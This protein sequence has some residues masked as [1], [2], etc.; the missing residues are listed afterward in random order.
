MLSS[1]WDSRLAV[2]V[3][4]VM[5]Q[6]LVWMRSDQLSFVAHTKGLCHLRY[7]LN[8]NIPWIQSIWSMP[9]S[10]TQSSNSIAEHA[11]A[12]LSVCLI[13]CLFASWHEACCHVGDG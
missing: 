7:I 10:M 1:P 2:S 13:V 4:A 3:T 9:Y 5:T 11:G 8:S 12:R 6:L